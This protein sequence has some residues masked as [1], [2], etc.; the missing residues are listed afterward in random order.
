MKKQGR[1]EKRR[2]A[3]GPPSGRFLKTP[4]PVERPKVDD[5]KVWTAVDGLA[6]AKD[7]QGIQNL[8]MELRDID[9]TRAENLIQL[10]KLKYPECYRLL[11]RLDGRGSDSY[12]S[13][14]VDE[15]VLNQTPAA[16]AAAKKDNTMRNV[17]GALARARKNRNN[18]LAGI[19]EI[20]RYVLA[21]EEEPE[22]VTDPDE[23]GMDFGDDLGAEG[24]EGVLDL[25][26]LDLDLGDMDLPGEEGDL[27]EDDACG[28][29]EGTEKECVPVEDE[30]GE[31]EEG[32]GEEHE[33]EETEEEEEEEHEE[34]GEEEGE[35]DE[36]GEEKPAKKDKK[37]E[38]SFM[39]QRLL[40][41]RELD[42]LRE[43]NFDLVLFGADGEDPHYAVFANGYPVAEIRQ[44]DQS[45]LK[46]E[47]K[48]M[49]LR[50]S[51]AGVVK[52]HIKAMGVVDTLRGANARFYAAAAFE[53]EVAANLKKQVTAS[54]QEEQRQK[55][56][57][58][59]DRLLNVTAMVLEGSIKNYYGE[60]ALKAS[61]QAQM[62]RLGMN[63]NA[64]I[65]AIEAAWKTAAAPY[66]EEVLNRADQLLGAHA[67]VLQHHAEE[68]ARREWTH[69][70]YES[71]DMI[72]PTTAAT[73][74][75]VPRN[76]PLVSGPVAPERPVQAGTNQAWDKDYW[77]NK[78][79]FSKRLANASQANIAG[80]VGRLKK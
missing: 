42:A 43:A 35:E 2:L 29:P 40:T 33:E 45:N 57:E 16:V 39:L 14:I 72:V 10:I 34:G 18:R 19:P 5:R 9:V 62:K 53:G 25:D 48:D 52:E 27:G 76:V 7:V 30:E 69:P 63:D 56:A 4:A 8:I 24:D 38:S 21:A 28:C 31:G 22:F 79:Q 75:V 36:E 74:D 15:V 12:T 3:L 60:N 1:N 78:L 58:L 20:D 55:L 6:R 51:Y 44:S 68:I 17:K 49:F 70:G 46:G 37:K 65:D 61:L 23:G 80:F 71:E 59:K 50:E 64:A 47:F 73:T 54:M 13:E 11:L 66:F 67:D 32:E 41:E 77:R 26:A